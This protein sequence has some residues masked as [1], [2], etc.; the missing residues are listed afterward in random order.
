MGVFWVQTVLRDAK[1][2]A[3]CMA[4]ET[5]HETLEAF[6]VDIHE[7]GVV[8]GTRLWLRPDGSGSV[9]VM[10]RSAIAIFKPGCLVVSPYEARRIYEVPR[11][12]P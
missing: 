8:V 1:E 3:V 9:E 11:E 7:V 10:R 6:I 2:R 12:M 4:V 5:D